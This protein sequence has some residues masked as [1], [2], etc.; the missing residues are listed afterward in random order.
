MF[1]VAGVVA[2]FV[3]VAST[4]VVVVPA[5]P[6]ETLK[7][8]KVGFSNTLINFLSWIQHS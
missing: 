8:L 7:L 1:V 6:F 2:R 3:V 4:V 5:S